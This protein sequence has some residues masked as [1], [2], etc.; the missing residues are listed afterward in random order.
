[1]ISFWCPDRGYEW[2]GHNPGHEA[3]TAYGLLHF[4]DMAKVRTVDQNM[5][6]TT[7]AWLMRQ[8]DGKGGFT[9]KARSSHSWIEDQDSSNAYIVWALMETG[10]SATNLKAELALLKEVADKSHNSYVVALAANALDI[11]GDKNESQKL[12]RRLA[13]LQR[14]NG[15]VDKIT[16][17]IVGSSGGVVGA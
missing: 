6:A 10:E 9:R 5:F 15:S 17:S 14:S 2:F 1:M 8:R 16:N 11:A 4:A 3:L 13:T 7:R 12:M